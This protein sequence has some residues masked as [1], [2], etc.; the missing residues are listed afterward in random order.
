MRAS[1]LFNVIENVV[2]ELQNN[3]QKIV[4]KHGWLHL[5]SQ[6]LNNWCHSV[7]DLVVIGQRLDLTLS[8]LND[9]MNLQL[10]MHTAYYNCIVP[11]GLIHY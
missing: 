6:T 2:S 1:F 8:N 9:S 4:R 10:E 5:D 11:Q 7:V 3:F